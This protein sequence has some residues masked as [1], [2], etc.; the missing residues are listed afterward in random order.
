MHDIIFLCSHKSWLINSNILKMVFKP[1]VDIMNQKDRNLK[2]G[3][4]PQNL[5]CTRG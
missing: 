1:E 4:K 3:L 5:I 2:S